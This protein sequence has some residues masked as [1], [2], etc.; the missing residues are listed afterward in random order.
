MQKSTWNRVLW[1]ITK[2]RDRSFQ[3][4]EVRGAESSLRLKDNRRE[5][6]MFLQVRFWTW[7]RKDRAVGEP[8][9]QTVQLF[10]VSLA[11]VSSSLLLQMMM[12]HT[13]FEEAMETCLKTSSALCPSV[14]TPVQNH[15]TLFTRNPHV[16]SIHNL[17]RE[18]LIMAF[19]MVLSF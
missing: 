12:P 7:W 16:L 5:Q 15:Q 2:Q 11:L 4:Q 6:P 14:P 18:N 8:F 19:V 13:P 3:P 9:I 1:G 10:L 17:P